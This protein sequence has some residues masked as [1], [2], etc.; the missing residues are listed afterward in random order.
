MKAIDFEG[1]HFVMT[2]FFKP[3]DT[4]DFVSLTDKGIRHPLI[5]EISGEDG[6][7]G[8]SDWLENRLGRS[9]DIAYDPEYCQFFATAKSEAAGREWVKKADRVLDN[10][11]Q[12]YDSLLK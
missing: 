8:F 3:D 1:K 6:A 7:Y 5:G 2:T 9:E 10:A 12:A 11:M 4:I